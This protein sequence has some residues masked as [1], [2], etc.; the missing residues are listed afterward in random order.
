MSRPTSKGK[1]FGA[2]SS[3]TTIVEQDLEA[4]TGVNGGKKVTPSL[5]KGEGESAL[6]EDKR[7]EA[8]ERLDD[9]WQHDRENPRNW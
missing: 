4:N 1:S 3:K 9:D 7:L 6:P 2:A 5:R 8:L